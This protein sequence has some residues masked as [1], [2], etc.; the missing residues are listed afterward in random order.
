MTYRELIL[1]AGVSCGFCT[2]AWI[3]YAAVTNANKTIAKKP[4]DP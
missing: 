3:C 2:I 4:G 1:M